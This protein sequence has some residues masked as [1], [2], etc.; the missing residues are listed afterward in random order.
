M[1]NHK[2]GRHGDAHDRGVIGQHAQG[3]LFEFAVCHFGRDFRRHHQSTKGKFLVVQT[4][5]HRLAQLGGEA[6][7]VIVDQCLKP[8]TL[9]PVQ[10][11]AQQ[12]AEP[13]HG[14]QQ[15]RLP[16]QESE[17]SFFG[18]HTRTSVSWSADL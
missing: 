10:Q 1:S 17:E 9:H 12:E 5:L 3:D 11:H 18:K 7:D 16:Y 2:I 8:V 6:F 13:D 4:G 15:G 14:Q